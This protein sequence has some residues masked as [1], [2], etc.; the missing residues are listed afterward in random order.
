MS[1]S[2]HAEPGS[3]VDIAGTDITGEVVELPFARA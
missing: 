1:R 2:A 3:V